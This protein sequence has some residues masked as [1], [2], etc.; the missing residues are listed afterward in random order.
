MI[1]MRQLHSIKKE[2]FISKLDEM[3]FNIVY[4]ERNGSATSYTN[5]V[6]R[7]VAKTRKPVTKVL[8]FSEFK[9]TSSKVL[10]GLIVDG[11]VLVKVDKDLIVY[12]VK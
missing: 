12:F 1:N 6:G 7:I 9:R 10:Q 3:P 5:K 8:T 4:E 2:D 11:A